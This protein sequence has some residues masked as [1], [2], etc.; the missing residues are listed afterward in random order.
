MVPPP[1]LVLRELQS[2]AR[3]VAFMEFLQFLQRNLHEPVLVRLRYKFSCPLPDNAFRG[4]FSI[5]DDFP[6]NLR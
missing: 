4:L 1:R 3:D 5:P 6:D 2:K